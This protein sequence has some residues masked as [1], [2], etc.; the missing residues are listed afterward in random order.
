MMLWKIRGFYQSGIKSENKIQ[1]SLKI[2]PRQFS[3][4]IKEI[5]NWTNKQ[6]NEA[7]KLVNESDQSL[8]MSR[9]TS[10]VILDTL[11]FKLI[12]LK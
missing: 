6:L 11:I 12:N 8:K 10:D 2:Y 3:E 1:T 5:P 9:M 7:I 4:Y